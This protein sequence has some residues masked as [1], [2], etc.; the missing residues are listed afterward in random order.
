MTQFREKLFPFLGAVLFTLVLTLAGCD[1]GV[2]FHLDVRVDLSASP[3]H[4]SSGGSISFTF[5]NTGE[6]SVHAQGSTFE[7][8]VHDSSG[9]EIRRVTSPSSPASLEADESV[10]ATWD[11]RDAGGHL[12]GSGDFTVSVAYTAAGSSSTRTEPFTID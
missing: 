1:D 5:R 10:A 3:D 4:A 2:S 6:D 11:Q 9:M 8:V 12:A 7:F